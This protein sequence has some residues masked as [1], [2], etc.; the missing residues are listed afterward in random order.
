M[1]INNTNAE[2][3]MISQS[4]RDTYPLFPMTAFI[5]YKRPCNY[6][7]LPVDVFSNNFHTQRASLMMPKKSTTKKIR[8]DFDNK[9]TATIP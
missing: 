4:L 5:R 1:L 2:I 3:P 8:S 9:I 7:V 6:Q